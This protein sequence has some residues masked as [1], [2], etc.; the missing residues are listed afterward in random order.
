LRILISDVC[1]DE[2]CFA[3]TRTTKGSIHA[4]AVWPKCRPWHATRSWIHFCQP[5]AQ[6][7]RRF[8]EEFGRDQGPGHLYIFNLGKRKTL[9]C[10]RDTQD[11]GRVIRQ[12]GLVELR[13]VPLTGNITPALSINGGGEGFGAASPFSLA[14]EAVGKGGHIRTVLIPNWVKAALDHWTHAAN[15]TEGK[16]FRAVA[17]MGRCAAAASRRTLSGTWSEPAARK[18]A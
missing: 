10:T 14:S 7:L 6:L 2:L 1:P 9:L 11:P 18:P 8:L 13:R 12:Y 15:V 16:I 17:R 5:I 4:W 3:F